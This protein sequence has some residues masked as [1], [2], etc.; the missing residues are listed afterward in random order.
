MRGEMRRKMWGENEALRGHRLLLGLR[1]LLVAL[2]EVAAH[3]QRARVQSLCLLMQLQLLLQPTQRVERVRE[4]GVQPGRLAEPERLGKETVNL[5][6]HP[7]PRHKHALS[8]QARPRTAT[9]GG[10]V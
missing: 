1:R 3:R 8:T 9:G 7:E 2:G 5:R 4:V 10:A 6:R